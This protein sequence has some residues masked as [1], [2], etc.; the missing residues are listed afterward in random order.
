M[1]VK[2]GQPIPDGR[3]FRLGVPGLIV[4]GL[5]IVSADGMIADPAGV[6]PDELTL[7]ADQ[8]FFRG[9]LAEADVLVHGRN[10][11]EGGP[12]AAARM[13]IVLTRRIDGAARDPQNGKRVLWNPA[14]ANFADAWALLAPTGTR[15]VVIGGTDVFGLFLEAGY[16]VFHL[17]RAANA[18]LP[19]GRAVFPGVPAHS[20]EELL[21]GRGLKPSVTRVLD[22]SAGLTL[23]TWRP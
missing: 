17:S 1:I 14:G 22:Q 19:G 4:E 2:G 23:T 7:D 18:R 11:G 15:A 21:A 13:R 6:Q 8:R 3:P 5:A 9:V 12:L 16:D 10:S 20:P